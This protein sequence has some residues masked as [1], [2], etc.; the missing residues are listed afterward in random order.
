[1]GIGVLA[2]AHSL[3]GEAE[4]AQAAEALGAAGTAPADAE[5][6]EAVVIGEGSET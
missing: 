6:E 4:R 3:L 2:T 1:V 5:E